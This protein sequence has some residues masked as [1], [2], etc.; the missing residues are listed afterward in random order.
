MILGVGVGVKG[1]QPLTFGV[2]ILMVNLGLQFTRTIKNYDQ[3]QGSITQRT[4]DMVRQLCKTNWFLS[5]H[6]NVIQTNKP[7]GLMRCAR[8]RNQTMNM[9]PFDSGFARG[10]EMTLLSGCTS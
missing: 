10:E 2:E 1:E 5:E 8:A 9:M 4:P 6:L 7:S 3:N